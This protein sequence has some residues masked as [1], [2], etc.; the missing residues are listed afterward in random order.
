M[1]TSS[2]ACNPLP[3]PAAR[4][5]HTLLLLC[6]LQTINKSMAGIVKNLASSLKANNLEKV[7]ETMDQVRAEQDAGACNRAWLW[8]C[9]LVLLHRQE[10]VDVPEVYCLGDFLAPY[11]ACLPAYQLHTSSVCG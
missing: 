10:S 2:S 7:A 4:S 9:C 5:T 1:L 3:A 11:N 6:R 8:S